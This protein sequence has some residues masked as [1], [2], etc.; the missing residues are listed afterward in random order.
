[1]KILVTGGAGFIGSNIVDAYI[2]SGHSVT[3]IDNLSSGKMENINSKA[4]FYKLDIRDKK[5]SKI[6]KKKRFD[7]VNH[8]A[9]QIDVRLSVKDPK[10]DADI[11][12]CG[13]LNILNACAESKV[14]KII[15]SSSG[16]TIYGECK[17]KPPDEA[18]MTNPLSP[19]GVSKLSGE[20]YIRCYSALY[21]LKYTILRYA[22]V[23]GP[24]QDPFGEAGV[25][26]IFCSRFLNNEDVFIYGDGKQMRDYVYVGD[27]VIVNVKSLKSGDNE[28][29]NIGTGEAISV[30]E[31]YRSMKS[32]G[33]F[34]SGARHKPPRGGELYKSFLDNAKAKKIL[35]W[36][37]E[38]DLTAGL[39][40]TIDYFRKR[41]AE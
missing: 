32:A 9:A 8:H 13:M 1:M 41:R 4:E 33:N 31:L 24:R 28:I 12:I 19:Y 15:F 39:K 10:L 22:N 3:V 27:V 40:K 17:A 25:V 20:Y 29:F 6:I 35:G 21:G 18:S 37:P 16:G 38:N 36:R 5:I 23:F 26:A 11:N 14:K 34:S 30:N 2:K 7:V